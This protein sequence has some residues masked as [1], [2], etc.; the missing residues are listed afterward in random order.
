MPKRIVDGD[1]PEDGLLVALG[2]LRHPPAGP[3][4]AP[5]GSRSSRVLVLSGAAA[6]PERGQAKDLPGKG[7]AI[8]GRAALADAG[9]SPGVMKP[10]VVLVEHGADAS[11]PI[12][13]Q[14]SR[15]SRDR[16]RVAPRPGWRKG[17]AA[18]VEAFPSHDGAAQ[19]DARTT[20]SRTTCRAALE[21][22]RSATPRRRRAEDRDFVHA[23]YGNF[24]VRAR[25]RH[26]AD[27]RPADARVP[28]DPAAAEGRDPESGLARRR[29]RDHRLHLPGGPRLGGDLGRARD[30][31]RSS[32]GS[33]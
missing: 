11:A 28:F 13:G 31:T 23:V 10:F 2:A 30:R 21:R 7:D 9:I 6:E 12:V 17:D 22:H 14:G 25:V 26:P 16:R 19:A 8:V 5:S 27:L 15:R 29:L 4:R 20:I 24:L 1:R 32:P 33:R 18:L 3:G